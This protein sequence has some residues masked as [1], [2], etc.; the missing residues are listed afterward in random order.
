LLSVR[1]RYGSRIENEKAQKDSPSRADKKCLKFAASVRRDS[2]LLSY[3]MPKKV[4]DLPVLQRSLKRRGFTLVEDMSDATLVLKGVPRVTFKQLTEG[5]QYYDMVA[6]LSRIGSKKKTQLATLRNHVKK[7]ACTFE[8]LGVQPTSWDMNRPSECKSFFEQHE[9]KGRM[10]VFKSCKAG[11]GSK[12]AGISVT[13][14]LGEYREQ[15]SKCEANAFNYVAQHYIEHP[16]LIKNRKFD[17]RVYI[18]VA[19]TQPYIVFFNPG[20]IRRS[21]AEYK[22]SSTEKSDVLTNYHVQVTRADFS[23][24]EALWSFNQFVEYLK[25]EKMCGACGDVEMQLAKV[26]VC[27][28]GVGGRTHASSRLRRLHAWCLMPGANT[29]CATRGRSNWW[30]WTL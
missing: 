26:R 30:G 11:E 8:S 14:D 17:M 18:L 25:Q 9:D 16:L 15:W 27:V 5:K 22:P 28:S 6:S 23:P 19:S 1:R 2:T 3:W 7:F 24:A 20:Y 12:G 10:I 13:D 21:L 4:F 29:T